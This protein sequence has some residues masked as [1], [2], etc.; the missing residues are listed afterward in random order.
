MSSLLCLVSIA[1]MRGRVHLLQLLGDLILA[2][3]HLL[4]A[5]FFEAYNLFEQRIALNSLLRT[6]GSLTRQSPHPFV[7]VACIVGFQFAFEFLQP[8]N[9]M[10][11]RRQ[12]LEQCGNVAARDQVGLANAD[13]TKLHQHFMLLDN[14]GGKLFGG[15][16]V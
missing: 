7:R 14:Q 1:D 15:L 2:F 3:G 6:A 9:E 12:E 4:G 10:L 5:E 13:R 8:A 16:H 11:F